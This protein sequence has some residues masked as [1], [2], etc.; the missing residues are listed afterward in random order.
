M[1]RAL[2]SHRRLTAVAAVTCASAG[3][4]P[5]SVP[6]WAAPPVV[7]EEWV[8]NVTLDSATLRATLDPEGSD[9]TYRFEYGT[10]STYGSRVP[11][12]DVDAGSGSSAQVV[13][14]P[15]EGL[16]PGTVYHYRLLTSSNGM[17]AEGPDHTF[18]TF[19]LTPNSLPD[20]RGY[21]LV[22]PVDKN[23]GEVD[24]G[25]VDGETR[26]PLQ[27][28][29][30]G[31]AVTYASA[32]GFEG[33]AREAEGSVYRS[34]Y[35]SRRGPVGWS[36]ENITPPTSAEGHVNPISRQDDSWEA[37]A[38]DLSA[39]FV[40]SNSTLIPGS[41]SGYDMPY[42]R[43]DA[44]GA[45]QALSPVAPPHLQAGNYSSEVEGQFV[46]FFAG[47]SSDF[48]HIAFSAND[49]LTPDAVA[50]ANPLDRN[51][52]EW[53]DGHL[54]LVNILPDGSVLPPSSHPVFGTNYDEGSEVEA[55]PGGG[56][57]SNVVS[58][59]GSRIFWLDAADKELFARVNGTTTV[60]LSKSEKTNGAGP[61]GTDPLGPRPPDFQTASADGSQVFFS[62]GEELTNAANTGNA[63]SC[64]N[65][66]RGAEYSQGDCGNDLYRYSMKDGTLSDLTADS[67]DP[68]GAELRAGAIASRDGSYVYFVA[69]GVL[70]PGAAR[71][72][73]PYQLYGSGTELH[74]NLY[75]WHEGVGTRF[76]ARVS[77]EEAELMI[78]EGAEGRASRVSPNGR[79]F[80]FESL[81]SLTGYGN[82][83]MVGAECAMGP[84]A[85]KAQ[86]TGTKSC[87]EVFLYDAQAGS[88]VCASCNPTG[89]RP[90]GR[91]IL[92]GRLSD[93]GPL[94]QGYRN[95]SGWSTLFYQQRYLSDEGRLFFE[96]LDA[97]SPRDT[98]G[99]VDVYEYEPTGAGTCIVFGAMFE[100]QADGCVALISGG[101]GP[102][103]SAF[104]D[105]SA[106]GDDVFIV[107]RDQ[108][109]P[110]DQDGAVDMYDAH[111]GALSSLSTPPPCASS[112]ACKP[113]PAP[114]PAVFG[115][116]A[117]AT[118]SGA[119]NISL[120]P[121]R[122]VVKPRSLTRAQRLTNALK[123]CKKKRRS[124]R[125][126]CERRARERYS[127]AKK[128][129]GR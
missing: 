47:A 127:H 89:A 63:E 2:V 19:A 18:R 75:V 50:S 57:Y 1:N 125:A 5:A 118:F 32:T 23:G 67:A 13:G 69:N 110:R 74:C 86:L 35:L 105:A 113:G 58:A 104:I 28:S 46:S 99:Q 30:D 119:G 77:S 121:T 53:A 124:T 112:D 102:E 101:F 76:I 70:A 20:G 41:F 88:L 34:S 38:P 33:V 85:K 82:T 26:A 11:M 73:C 123:A 4:L 95:A 49:A 27:A 10:S 91:S 29:E 93:Q 64:E 83:V 43:E 24:E 78:T 36:T 65:S 117:S 114:Q 45:Y 115:A 107:T 100:E 39:G 106:N 96:T 25:V 15:V 122:P 87:T 55:G 6:A 120:A 84:D 62:S 66:L 22:S 48:S 81:Q 31:S 129:E 3:L 60:L 52:Y 68:K 94:N 128:K 126:A 54:R 12:R 103:T 97:L 8:E 116:P 72:D 56:A 14:V 92:P 71:G 80:T 42:R 98:N 59:D 40:I 108:L 109:S 90:I 79:F 37:M 9:T 44:S 7:E 111:V 51:L 17:T 16:A 61:G 21:E